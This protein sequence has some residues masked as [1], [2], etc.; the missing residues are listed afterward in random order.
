MLKAAGIARMELI[1]THPDSSVCNS[2]P[3]GIGRLAV[4]GGQ[5]VI[6]NLGRNI[7]LSA[8]AG[9]GLELNWLSDECAFPDDDERS[10]FD[11]DMHAFLT[12]PDGSS[13]VAVNHYGRVSCFSAA[14]LPVMRSTPWLVPDA[15]L[16]WPG[17]VEQFAWLGNGL[18]STSPR[19]YKCDDPPATGILISEEPWD[20]ALLRAAVVKGE[21]ISPMAAHR[22]RYQRLLSDWGYTT[23]L[24]VDKR[25]LII[26]VAAGP[27]VGV[28]G[29]SLKDGGGIQLNQM[30]WEAELPFRCCWLRFVPDRLELA[31]AGFGIDCP[32]PDAVDWSALG[33]GGFAV[34]SA[35]RGKLLA[36]GRF[37]VDLAWGNGGT[38][39]VLSNGNSLFCGV[40]RNANLYSWDADG[41][42][43]VLAT[44][45]FTESLGIAHLARFR[46][47][48]FCGFNRGGYTVFRYHLR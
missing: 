25:H 6:N 26:A 38:P 5:L 46:D 44:T 21:V 20:Q 3:A 43:T 37:E 29:A 47:D 48:L 4:F 22:L 1:R 15:H 17:D 35:D 28:F 23:A 40:D 11:L 27:R 33:G 13:L 24:A 39:L 19:G 2:Q 45:R 7:E 14:L 34:L 31:A 16:L 42:M 10:Q 36:S 32:D 12:G 30:Q 41:T 18:I 8:V 9:Q